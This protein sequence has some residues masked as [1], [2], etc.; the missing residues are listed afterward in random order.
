MP[1]QATAFR[2]TTSAKIRR[3]LSHELR[4]EQTV[5]T[6]EF[7]WIDEVTREDACWV[8]AR[9]QG[10]FGTKLFD[11]FIDEPQLRSIATVGGL[12]KRIELRIGAQSPA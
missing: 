2:E 5:L 4:L 7:S 12:V 8:L 6:D 1:T 3:I 11:D 10:T 9:I